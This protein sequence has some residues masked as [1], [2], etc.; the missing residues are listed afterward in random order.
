MTSLSPAISIKS[1]YASSPEE[2]TVPDLDTEDEFAVR[3]LI[4][5]VVHR[6]LSAYGPSREFLEDAL[7]RHPDVEGKWI[8]GLALFELAV[9]ELK[10]AEAADAASKSPPSDSDVSASAP[11]ALWKNAIRAATEKLDKAVALSGSNV[12]LSS[13][14]D[15]RVAMLR[16]EI[17]LKKEMMGISD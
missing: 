3:S 14:L 1:P 15:T 10:E 9:L 13:R 8:G 7:R 11:R 5:G 16:D 6:T 2:S 4:L 12:D 17:V